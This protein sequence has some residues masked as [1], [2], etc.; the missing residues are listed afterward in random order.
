M[1]NI[2]CLLLMLIGFGLIIFSKYN[3]NKDDRGLHQINTLKGYVGGI[4][5]FV[6][7]L[8]TLLKNL[9]WSQ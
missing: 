1:S 5:L 8:L 4:L 3:Y 9:G 7:G 2:F 6:F